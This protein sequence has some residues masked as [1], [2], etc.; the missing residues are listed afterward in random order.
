MLTAA[1]C[2]AA[3][4]P[5]EIPVET[6][7]TGAH[8]FIASTACDL[9][10]VQAEDLAG[11]RVGVNLPGTDTERPNWRL[12]LPIPV[13]TLLEGPVAQAILDPVRA[14]RGTGTPPDQS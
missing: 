6:V 5:V 12:R 4:D 9:M 8:Q 11:M 1:G 14:V 3:A 10:L 13:E 7:V 2:L